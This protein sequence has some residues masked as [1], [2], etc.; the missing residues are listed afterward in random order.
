MTNIEL[1]GELN[2]SNAE[3][4]QKLFI[5]AIEKQKPITVE[6]SKIEDIDVSIVQL[7]IALYRDLEPNNTLKFV[8]DFSQ[9]VKTRLYTMGFC[10]SEHLSTQA[11]IDELHKIYEGL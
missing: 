2:I 7:F 4:I 3:E 6:I 1:Q 8:G 5:S 10:S 9:K 11:V